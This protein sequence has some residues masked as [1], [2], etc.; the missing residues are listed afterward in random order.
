MPTTRALAWIWTAV[1]LGLHSIPRLQLERIPG[2]YDLVRSSGP[3]KV[4][5]VALFAI[6]GLL[7]SCCSPRRPLTILAAGVTY[8]VALELY[9]G[10]LIPGRSCSPTDVLANAVGT[11][12]G[13]VAA[14]G[15]RRWYQGCP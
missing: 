13:I 14:T 7:W 5:H 8:G 12:L 1:M 2:A 15:F 3:D 4:V 11:G 10:W 9:Q 6:F